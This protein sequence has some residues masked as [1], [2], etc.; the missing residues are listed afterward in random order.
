MMAQPP[1]AS[2]KLLK[3]KTV[4]VISQSIYLVRDI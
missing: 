4:R 2:T 1:P 3:R